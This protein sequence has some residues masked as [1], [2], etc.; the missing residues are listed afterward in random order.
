MKNWFFH[1]TKK[2]VLVVSALWLFGFLCI[3]VAS[4]FFKN[5]TLLIVLL[6]FTSFSAVVQVFARYISARKKI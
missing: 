3:L 4:D 5:M 1:P 6:L 2:T